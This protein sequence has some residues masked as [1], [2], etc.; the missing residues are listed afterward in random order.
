MSKTIYETMYEPINETLN[1]GTYYIGDPT[2][3]LPNEILIGIWGNLYNFNNGK[4]NINATDFC[5]H[6]THNGDGVY[7]D[8]RNR[9]YIVDGGVL[10]IVNIELIKDINLCNNGYIYKFNKKIN[11][12]YDVGIFIIK[13]DKK[14]IKIDTHNE[15]ECYSDEDERSLDNDGN[16]IHN[17]YTNDSDDDFIDDINDTYVE[18]YEDDE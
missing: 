2:L 11:F 6:N 18:Y 12:Y 14:Y 3:V 16:N 9:K 8:T 5:V 17:V 13:S 7:Y 15:N 4:F 10:G 1:P